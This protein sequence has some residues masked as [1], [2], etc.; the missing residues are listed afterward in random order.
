MITGRGKYKLK[1][2]WLSEACRLAQGAW[3][4][5]L[6]EEL[7]HRIEENFARFNVRNFCDSTKFAKFSLHKILYLK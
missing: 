5:W 7:P 6:G 4:M 1:T 3:L 2:Q